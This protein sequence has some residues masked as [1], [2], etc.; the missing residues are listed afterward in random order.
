[1]LA[2][3]SPARGLEYEDRNQPCS[4]GEAPDTWAWS[5]AS[6]QGHGRREG[7]AVGAEALGGSTAGVG[8]EVRSEGRA[9]G[10]RRGHTGRAGVTWPG[11]V[12]QGPLAALWGRSSVRW[13]A[14]GGQQGGSRVPSR[15]RCGS[16]VQWQ[17]RREGHCRLGRG[18]AR[19]FTEQADQSVSRSIP[20]GQVSE[21]IRPSIR[22]PTVGALVHLAA[23]S[24]VRGGSSAP[25]RKKSGAGQRW[26]RG[27]ARLQ[28]D[29]GAGCGGQD[30]GAQRSRWALDFIFSDGAG[31]PVLS[32]AQAQAGTCAHRL[33]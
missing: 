3:L 12:L 10:Q 16:C 20:A 11:C 7:S 19:A 18:E 29:G 9:C 6:Q 27:A 32:R 14:R 8:W 4:A 1:M 25:R 15:G 28:G 24:G 23:P 26:A 5:K 21:D 30:R 22:P 17:E 33:Q 2:G 31:H 13:G